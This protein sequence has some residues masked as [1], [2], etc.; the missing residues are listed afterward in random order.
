M[1][2]S[3]YDSFLGLAELGI[4]KTSDL[5]AWNA[6]ICLRNR[7]VHA[8]MN[9]VMP[10]VLELVKNEQYRFVTDFLLEPIDAGSKGV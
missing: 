2:L 9:I 4:V 5:T 8:Y 10:R 1:P 6:I 3:A 7:I